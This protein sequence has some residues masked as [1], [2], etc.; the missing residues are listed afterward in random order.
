MRPFCIFRK[1]SDI[2]DTTSLSQNADATRMPHRRHWVITYGYH[3]GF[4]DRWH[5]TSCTETQSCISDTAMRH[6]WAVARSRC[7]TRPLSHELTTTHPA[8]RTCS[9][10]HPYRASS[11]TGNV[12]RSQI[13]DT[14]F[15]SHGLACDIQGVSQNINA[16]LSVCRTRALR[17]SNH[18]ALSCC[19][20][21]CVSH[22]R[23]VTPGSCH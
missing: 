3:L 23:F 13:C 20:T 21:P 2:S 17:H 11:G 1:L 10:R 7:D 22:T 19:D 4:F 16:T 9:L 5:I 8:C 12:M 6:T 14:T 15:V 18:V